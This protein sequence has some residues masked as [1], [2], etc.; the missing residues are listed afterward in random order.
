MNSW[1][2]F[3]KKEQKIIFEKSKGSPHHLKISFKDTISACAC[4]LLSEPEADV[5]GFREKL[6]AP[7]FIFK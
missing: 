1:Q 4:S 3:V 2:R 5:Q 7:S 6:S